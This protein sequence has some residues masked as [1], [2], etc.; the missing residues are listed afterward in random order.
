MKLIDTHMNIPTEYK[1]SVLQK[2]LK[3]VLTRGEKVEKVY[4]IAQI[5]FVFTD[6]RLIIRGTA[7]ISQ[8][9]VPVHSIPY[10]S[11]THF[12][13]EPMKETVV[14]TQ[15][16]I[17]LQG[18]SIPLQKEL[19]PSPMVT[20][21]HQTL[22]DYVLNRHS[23]WLNKQLAWKKRSGLS[24]IKALVFTG[25][26]VMSVVRFQKMHRKPVS[27]VTKMTCPTSALAAL[28]SK[29]LKG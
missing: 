13:M 8:D 21:L 10:R 20:A 24:T 18:D 15:L 11:I 6:K 22:A 19:V 9:S 29:K 23:P 27:S 28:L 2:E 12:S 17:W 1:P 26:A 16:Y 7:G 3:E 14:G 25:T 4:P 5:V